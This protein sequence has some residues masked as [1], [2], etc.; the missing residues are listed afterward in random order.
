MFFSA[1]RREGFLFHKVLESDN[2]MPNLVYKTHF[3]FADMLSHRGQESLE[4][5][6]GGL[7]SKII[8]LESM[9]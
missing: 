6:I 9:V 2:I 8:C 4:L 3:V 5:E 1:A 7:I